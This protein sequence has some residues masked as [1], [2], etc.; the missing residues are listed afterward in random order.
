MIAAHAASPSIRFVTDGRTYEPSGS[1]ADEFVAVFGELLEGPAFRPGLVIRFSAQ[2]T[3]PDGSA[4]YAKAQLDYPADPDLVHET[5]YM[6]LVYGMT[7]AE[8]PVG[9]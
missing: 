4:T 5:E 2:L 8:V 7:R 9:T 1:R 6:V 3:A